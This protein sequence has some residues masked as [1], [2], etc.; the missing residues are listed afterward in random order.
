MTGK[1]KTVAWRTLLSND[2]ATVDESIIRAK[3]VGASAFAN[4]RET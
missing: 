2:S 1:S 4:P 3:A